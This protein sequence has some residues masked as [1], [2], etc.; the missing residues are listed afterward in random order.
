MEQLEHLLGFE[1]GRDVLR[2][3]QRGV[4]LIELAIGLAILA[5]LVTLGLPEFREFIRNTKVKNVAQ[6]IETGLQLARAEA[7]R[8]N[9]PVRFQFVSDMTSSCAIATG[10][11]TGS[12]SWVVS[13]DNPAG[14]CNAA[15]SPTTAPRIIQK[16]DAR[17]TSAGITWDITL[18]NTSA[19]GGAITF[20]GLGRVSPPLPGTAEIHVEPDGTGEMA[21]TYASASGTVRCMRL[22]ITNGGEIKMCDPKVTDATD[23]R[24]CS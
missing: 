16:W 19:V 4:T 8:L 14:A 2:H 20:N 6:S 21:C 10:G 23:P 22:Q 17:E 15:P 12:P 11:T 3:R 24:I 5:I 9:A 13:R 7:L 18:V 1:E